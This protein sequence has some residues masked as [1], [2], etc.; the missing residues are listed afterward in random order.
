MPEGETRQIVV[1]IARAGALGNLEEA[2]SFPTLEDVGAHTCFGTSAFARL[3]FHPLNG[4]TK[5]GIVAPACFHFTEN[6]SPPIGD[7]T[8]GVWSAVQAAVFN[9]C[10]GHTCKEVPYKS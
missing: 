9:Y 2:L 8:H 3:T 5:Y 1:T 6:G 4:G 10:R 7:W